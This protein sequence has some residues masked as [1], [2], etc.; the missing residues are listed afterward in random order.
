MSVQE[1]IEQIFDEAGIQSDCYRFAL[2]GNHET[3]EYCVQYRESE[4]NFISRLMEEEG[5]FYFFEHDDEKHVMVMADN[6]DAHVAI[7]T[8][9]IVYNE[10]SSM[11]SDQESIYE[12]RFVQQIR[13]G[14]VLFRDFNFEQ[15][16]LGGMEVMALSGD[17]SP[18][19]EN[20]LE[21]YD[22]PG[23]YSEQNLGSDLAQIRLETLRHNR[24]IGS[25]SSVCR[26]FLPGYRFTMD[27]HSRSD[28]NQEYLITRVVSTATQPLGED[29][30][31]GSSY[32]NEFECIPY[33]V[34][35]RST[36]RA[37]RPLVE[38]VQ[39]AIVV[40]PAGEEIYTDEHG[41]VKVQFHWD[42]EGQNDENSSCWI[43]V[44]QG[45][46]GANWG[47]MFIPRI[48]Q[49]VIVDFLEGDPD[50]PIITGR[51]YN[52]DNT[53]PYPLPDNKTKS[54]VK[55]DSSKGGGGSNE[56]RF[57]DSKGNEEVYVHAQ[58]N[59]NEKV[60]NN[61]STSV[62]ANQSISVGGNRS[63]SVSKN[64]SYKIDG[65]ETVEIK[66]N[67]SKTVNGD[68]TITVK[69]TYTETI[70]KATKITISDGTYDH[71][72]ATGTAKYHVTGALT[73]N[74]DA[75]Q[76]T[77]VANEI[78]IKSSGSHIHITAST[79]ITLKVGA[80]QLSMKSDGTIELKGVKIGIKGTSVGID[81]SASVDI[82]GAS[83]TSKADASHT[84][85]GAIVL[86]EGAATNTVKGGMVMLNP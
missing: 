58:K 61:M 69:G 85:Q 49:E 31:E 62:G 16:S 11:V 75:S 55:S 48:G 22:Y 25:G 68:E 52:G 60:E 14:T 4:L 5:I 79:D 59:M 15:P 77:T 56:I 65:D 72:V 6:P 3:R 70:T 32:N 74:Y 41:R 17:Q 26:R 82:H 23:E 42:R 71:D 46:A 50:R 33:S 78:E 18:E 35:F 81:G 34:P 53:V 73:E 57:E 45:W 37:L 44:N 86:S 12:Y 8:P 39:T 28:F 84:T 67:R 9:T 54:T 80:S 29:S 47:A 10:A 51:V 27:R 40:G 76:K 24:Q 13:P 66:G 30:D 63:I 38:G 2:Q 1:I 20:N 83:V 21:V 64:E 36:R 19:Y 43:R 7:D